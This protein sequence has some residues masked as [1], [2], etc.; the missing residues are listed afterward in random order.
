MRNPFKR[1]GNLYGRRKIPEREP[2]EGHPRSFLSNKLKI[3]LDTHGSTLVEALSSFI[4]TKDKP[5]VLI[6][7]QK[8]LKS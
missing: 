5:H 7:N 8:K 1:L 2:L 6:A 4:S 3:L